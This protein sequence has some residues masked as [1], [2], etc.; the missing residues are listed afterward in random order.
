MN[1][2]KSTLNVNQLADKLIDV[3]DESVF[4]TDVPSDAELLRHNI[5]KVLEK[6]SHYPIEGSVDEAKAYASISQST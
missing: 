4:T 2:F 6:Y 5:I 3:F 1:K